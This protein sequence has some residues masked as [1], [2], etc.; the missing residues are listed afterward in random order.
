M[1]LH[2][3]TGYAEVATTRTTPPG[4]MGTYGCRTFNSAGALCQ[5]RCDVCNLT[6]K[7]DDGEKWVMLSE[8]VLHEFPAVVCVPCNRARLATA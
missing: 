5:P 3:I 1:A 2:P 8:G 4:I 6:I 7:V